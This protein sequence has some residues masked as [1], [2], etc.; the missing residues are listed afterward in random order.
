[1]TLNLNIALVYREKLG[2]ILVIITIENGIVIIIG[3][4]IIQGLLNYLTII[5]KALKEIRRGLA[6]DLTNTIIGTLRIIGVI[7]KKINNFV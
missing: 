6:I 7:A 2:P 4:N 1:L 3:G 5:N